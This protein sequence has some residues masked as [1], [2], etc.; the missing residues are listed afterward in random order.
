MKKQK[1]YG[2]IEKRKLWKNGFVPAL[3]VLLTVF[4]IIAL[5]VSGFSQEKDLK[6][7]ND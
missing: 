2:F 7:N 5:N 3:K 1:N 4:I 6:V